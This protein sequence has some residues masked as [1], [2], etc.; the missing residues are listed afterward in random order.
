M[1][2]A[3]TSGAHSSGKPTWKMKDQP[4]VKTLQSIVVGLLL[5]LI[6]IEIRIYG[7]GVSSLLGHYYLRLPQHA[8]PLWHNFEMSYEM[9]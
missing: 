2:V 4:D 1:L 7:R 9:L 6:H 5:L 3:Y 8:L